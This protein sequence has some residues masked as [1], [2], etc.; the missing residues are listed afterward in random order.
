MTAIAS[1]EAGVRDI[2][3]ERA[4]G[5]PDV[6]TVLVNGT[7]EVRDRKPGESVIAAIESAG[8]TLRRGD[9]PDSI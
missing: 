4:F 1:V 2:G 5:G 3:Y 6:S 8:I 7:I 9:E